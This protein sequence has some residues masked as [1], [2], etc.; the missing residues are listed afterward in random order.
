MSIR[1]AS[2]LGK[3]KPKWIPLNQFRA[4][5]TRAAAAA[6]SAA[7][8]P[9]APK[10]ALVPDSNGGSPLVPVSATPSTVSTASKLGESSAAKSVEPVVKSISTDVPS[11]AVK[12][13]ASE[14]KETKP[15]K[16]IPSGPKA[17]TNPPLRNGSSRSAEGPVNGARST[18]KIDP[19]TEPVVDKKEEDAKSATRSGMRSDAVA[20]PKA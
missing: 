4:A 3:L 8:S 1:Y 17:L 5:D 9:M 13:E 11:A 20:N 14:V 7:S 16:A 2:Q 6:R 12:V 18:D 10:A 19:K 15:E